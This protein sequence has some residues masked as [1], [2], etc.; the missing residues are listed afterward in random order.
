MAANA[1]AAQ[2]SIP[3]ANTQI[4]AV[5][6]SL[7]VARSASYSRSVLSVSW[8]LVVRCLSGGELSQAP[9]AAADKTYQKCRDTPMRILAQELV[10]DGRASAVWVG[11][12]ARPGPIIVLC[13]MD[14][15]LECVSPTCSGLKL[16]KVS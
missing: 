14:C 9:V 4:R 6:R 7:M 8:S 2:T 1:S 11:E 13:S 3:S 15:L 12:N 5:P 10:L 16:D